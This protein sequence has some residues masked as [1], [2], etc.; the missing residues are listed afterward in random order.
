MADAFKTRVA[1]E[2]ASENERARIY[3]KISLRLI[4]MIFLCYA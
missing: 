2:Q 4:P 1:I 3:R